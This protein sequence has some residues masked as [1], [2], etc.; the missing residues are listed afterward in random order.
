MSDDREPVQDDLA[1]DLDEWVDDPNDW[2]DVHA[3][4]KRAPK[5]KRGEKK[6]KR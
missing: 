2:I 6:G 3:R 4:R 1:Q 5:P